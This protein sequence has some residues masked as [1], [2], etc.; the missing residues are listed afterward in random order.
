MTPIRP[1]TTQFVRELESYSSKRLYHPDEVATLID[2]ARTQNLMEVFE[3]AAFHAKFLTKAFGVM[4][5]IGAE[6]EG[7]PQLA[8]E[9]QAS[10]EKASTLVKTLVKES[11]EELKQHFVQTFFSLRQESL[12]ELLHLMEDLTVVK[13]WRVDGR[14]LP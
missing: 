8:A 2:L 7:Y 14:P 4:Q 13:N 3:D 10:L 12:V 6:G 1:E 5:R 9:F 11:P